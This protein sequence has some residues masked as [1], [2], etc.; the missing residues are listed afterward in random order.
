LTWLDLNY[1][2]IHKLPGRLKAK[3][4]PGDLTEDSP[5]IYILKLLGLSALATGSCNRRG[6]I[7]LI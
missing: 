7:I 3:C 5:G 4:V 2:D 6:K 1:N